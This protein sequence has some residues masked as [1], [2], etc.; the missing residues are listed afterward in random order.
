MEY[1]ILERDHEQ[2]TRG[3]FVFAGEPFE[4]WCLRGRGSGSGR[5]V[6]RR[7][8]GRCLGCCGAVG[9]PRK[10][11]VAHERVAVVKACDLAARVAAEAND[12]DRKSTRLNSSHYLI[13]YAVFCLKKKILCRAGACAL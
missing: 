3:E 6:L 10:T 9:Q 11:D 8:R 13:S 5:R 4:S 2:A 12:Q 7:W 1:A